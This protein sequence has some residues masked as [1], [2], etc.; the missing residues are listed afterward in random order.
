VR[1]VR[2]EAGVASE[3]AA[4]RELDPIDYFVGDG[5]D[6][7]RKRVRYFVLSAAAEVELCPLPDR[8][9]E[10]RWIG[11]DEARTI[12]LVNEALRPLLLHALE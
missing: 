9:R 8:T 12:P 2:E 5:S 1:E 4:G 10:R 7:Y 11:I 6:R 3:L